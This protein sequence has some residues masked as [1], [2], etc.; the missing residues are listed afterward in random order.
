MTYIINNKHI[1]K[2]LLVIYFLAYSVSPLTYTLSDKQISKSFHA[3]NKESSNI[4][5]VHVLL[6]EFL[7]DRLSSA[8][9]P[10]NNGSASILI[11][12]K[13]ALAP[14]NDS[15]K[16]LSFKDASVSKDFYDPFV[17]TIHNSS[18]LP[19]H[20]FGI[21]AGFNLVYTGNSPPFV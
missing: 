18:V 21:S 2:L 15:V 17:P 11:K 20:I 14:E 10:H 12:K 7:I 1:F 19:V 8:E 4:K 6:W 5:S 13:R 16:L 9:D 3:T